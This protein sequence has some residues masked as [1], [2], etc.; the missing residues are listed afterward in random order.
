MLKD[1]D[2][3]QRAAFAGRMISGLTGLDVFYQGADRWEQIRSTQTPAGLTDTLDPLGFARRFARPQAPPAVVRDEYGFSWIGGRIRDVPIVV[4]PFLLTSPTPRG[5]QFLKQFSGLPPSRSDEEIQGIADVFLLA[6]TAGET[7]EQQHLNH[8]DIAGIHNPALDDIN[9]MDLPAITGRYEYERK[10]RDAVAR[11]DRAALS[12]AIGDGFQTRPFY[13]RMPG[14]PVRTEKN[15]TI[16]LNTILRTSA[17]E[18][19]LLPIHLHGISAEFALRVEQARHVEAFPPLR[20]EMM[21]RYCEAVREFTVTHH[22]AP[23]RTVTRHILSNLDQELPL[24]DLARRAGC[25]PSYL[26]RL[27][28]REHGVSIGTFIRRKRIS[29]ARW[30]L[31]NTDQPAPEIADAAGFRD[32]NYFRRVFKVETGTTPG[33]YRRRYR[34][35]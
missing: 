7:G 17:E 13:D 9:Q 34:H 29:E 3:I 25:S 1:S 6:D 28:R 27:F 35:R 24:P 5:V 32:L 31:A 15:L 4:G 8:A 21:Y 11:G 18:G 14:N 30:L 16:V 20:T 23:V 2:R 19:G 12:A 10:I 22:S 33:A 26:A